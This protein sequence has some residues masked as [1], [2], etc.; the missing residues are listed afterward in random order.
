MQRRN[1]ASRA[2]AW[3]ALPQGFWPVHRRDGM[4]VVGDGKTELALQREQRARSTV[5]H[6]TTEF[7]ADGERA[8]PPSRDPLTDP[9]TIPGMELLS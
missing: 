1:H 4:L 3:A 6:W 5:F 7:P 9:E 8:A 2:A